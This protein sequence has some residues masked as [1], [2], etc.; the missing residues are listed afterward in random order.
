M[1]SEANP[2]KQ[3]GS[4]HI[5][6]DNGKLGL[7]TSSFLVYHFLRQL[8]PCKRCLY[9]YKKGKRF[10]T[11]AAFDFVTVYPHNFSTMAIFWLLKPPP[12]F[13]Q[14]HGRCYLDVSCFCPCVEQKFSLATLYLH[15]NF[16][17]KQTYFWK[18]PA[19]LSNFINI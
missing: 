3:N 2:L 7:Q 5:R 14:K 8:R 19:K 16:D 9:V 13:R 11:K 4:H 17:I 1:A 6:K 18:L 10:L 15:H 12:S